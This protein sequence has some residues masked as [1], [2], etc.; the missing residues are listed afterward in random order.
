[1]NIDKY[2]ERIERID[3]LIRLKATGSPTE[4]A[5]KLEISSSLLYEYIKLLKEMGAPIVF[6][7]SLNSYTYKYNV[8]ISFKFSK[9]E[10]D[11]MKKINGGLSKIFFLTPVI[12]E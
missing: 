12:L 7:N 11:D 5:K 1:M 4:F 8:T 3:R 2:L 9:I 10:D 6:N